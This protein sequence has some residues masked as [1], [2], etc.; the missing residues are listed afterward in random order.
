MYMDKLI[1]ISRFIII[2]LCVLLVLSMILVFAGCDNS[3]YTYSDIRTAYNELV[4]QN[5]DIFNTAGEVEIVYAN[6]TLRSAIMSNDSTNEYCKLSNDEAN[7][8]AIFEP[9]FRASM[10][11]VDRY[12]NLG[13]PET[14]VFN[15]NQL[16]STYEKLMA[17]SSALQE[18]KDA[19]SYLESKANFNLNGATEVYWRDELFTRFYNL[20]IKASDFS[21]SFANIYRD[22]IFIDTD[23][24]VGNR[25]A[26]GKMQLE[27]LIKLAEYAQISAMTTVYNYYDQDASNVDMPICNTLLSE[28]EKVVPIGN[29]QGN[30]GDVISTDEQNV[31]DA[32]T[33]WLNYDSTFQQIKSQCFQALSSYD[34]KTMLNLAQNN[35]LDDMTI[36]QRS[37]YEKVIGF[38]NTECVNMTSYIISF[39]TKLLAFA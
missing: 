3:K 8:F 16:N 34:Y 5:T 12:I 13:Y 10:L 4:S 2:P 25:Y 23:Y 20:L 27:Y 6:A 37:C 24:S 38:F 11:V 15:S 17:F 28:Y 35:R 9:A 30:A 14:T 39:T 19:K 22:S 26:T 29:W 1:S 7:S 36:E 32:F 21:L 33:A 18:F 31:I